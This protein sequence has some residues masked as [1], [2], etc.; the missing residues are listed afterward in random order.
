MYFHVMA[1]KKSSDSLKEIVQAKCLKYSAPE[2]GK[3]MRFI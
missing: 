2:K 3:H 1:R